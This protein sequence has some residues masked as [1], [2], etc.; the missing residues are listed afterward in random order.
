MPNFICAVDRAGISIIQPDP[1]TPANPVLLTLT[2]TGG[3]FSKTDF[4]ASNPIQ[5]EMLAVALTA[6]STQNQV[7]VVADSPENGGG[8]RPHTPA[9]AEIRIIVD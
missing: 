5:K 2:D 7:F 9:C 4:V 8:G 3:T 1:D 6:I